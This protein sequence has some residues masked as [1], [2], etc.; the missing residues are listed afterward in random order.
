MDRVRGHVELYSQISL[1]F[2]F[3]Y[4]L[5]INIKLLLILFLSIYCRVVEHFGFDLWNR[6]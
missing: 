2:D 1:L 5:D 6:N 3:I 4:E